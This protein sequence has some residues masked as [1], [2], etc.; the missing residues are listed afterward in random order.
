MT[1]SVFEFQWQQ[2]NTTTGIWDDIPGAAGPVFAPSNDQAGKQL[3]VEVSYVDDHGTTEHVFSEATQPVGASLVGTEAADTITGTAGNDVISGLGGSD[4]L[5]GLAGNDTIDGGPAA[6]PSISG[7]GDDVLIGGAGNDNIIGAVGNDTITG[8]LGTD[9]INAGAGDDLINYTMG[10]GVD[11]I[12]GDTGSDTLKIVGTAG[13]DTLDVIYNGTFLTG[14]EGGTLSGV[15]TVTA[16]LLGG[17]DTLS[18]G[19]GT[20]AG[21]IVIGG[22]HRL[23]LHLDRGYRERNGWVR[24]RSPDR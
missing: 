9:I 6:T 19:T 14:I 4:T 15:E 13:A 5:N 3:R 1:T 16:D 23:G 2:F 21:V 7:A 24:C 10:D 17:S 18:Y 11:T 22:P 20:T 8:G 12:V